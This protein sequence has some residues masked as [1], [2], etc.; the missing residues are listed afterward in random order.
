MSCQLPPLK[1]I[2]VK[3]FKGG[4]VA[5]C[6]AS[7]DGMTNEVIPE[8]KKVCCVC[9][10]LQ[11]HDRWL[12]AVC[13]CTSS[14]CSVYVYQSMRSECEQRNFLPEVS[15]VECQ[16]RCHM[17]F[18]K[19]DDRRK[20]RMQ[21][22]CFI[23]FDSFASDVLTCKPNNATRVC[24]LPSVSTQRQGYLVAHVQFDLKADLFR[25]MHFIAFAYLSVCLS[26]GLS[27]CHAVAP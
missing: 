11:S 12:Y 9:C 17:L 25:N 19:L 4:E 6:L 1:I 15:S 14:N 20:R 23:C 26:V 27:V 24:F 2:S 5:T 8:R 22:H 16:P 3:V 7:C 18:D 13:K 10:Q 21:M